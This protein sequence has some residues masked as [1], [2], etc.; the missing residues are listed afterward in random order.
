MSFFERFVAKN[1]RSNKN[2]TRT[3]VSSNILKN[4]YFLLLKT[5]RVI[6]IIFSYSLVSALLSLLTGRIMMLFYYSYLLGM[7]SFSAHW[8]SYSPESTL[9]CGF[10]IRETA[11]NRMTHMTK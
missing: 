2:K 11:T 8:G 4:Y 10:A 5:K 7:E 1:K 9:S 6:Y 3:F